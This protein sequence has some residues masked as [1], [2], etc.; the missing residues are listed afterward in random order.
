[1]IIYQPMKK[2]VILFTLLY[3]SLSTFSQYSYYKEAFIVKKDST[4]LSGYI[5][6]VSE[7]SLNPML[8]FK[9][10]I[11]DRAPIVFPVTDIQRVVFVADSTIFENV[12]YVWRIDSVKITEER[13]AKKYLKATHVFTNFNYTRK[14]CQSYL[15]KTIRLFMW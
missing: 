12:N 9:K 2:I 8:K 14:K 5:E 1:M 10:N 15:S 7:S 6:K 4:R 3:S 11:E 13:L